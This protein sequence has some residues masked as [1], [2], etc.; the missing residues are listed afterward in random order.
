MRIHSSPGSHAFV[1]EAYFFIGIPKSMPDKTTA[2]KITA[3]HRIGTAVEF[4]F[5]GE[6]GID[7]LNTEGLIGINAEDIIIGGKLQCRIFLL[8]ISVESLLVYGAP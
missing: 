7:E 3:I 1:K 2:K 8:F 6:N 4:F 5:C